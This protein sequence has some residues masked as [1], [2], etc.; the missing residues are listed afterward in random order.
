MSLKPRTLRWIIAGG[1]AGLVSIGTLALV[2]AQQS[3]A[4]KEAPD[5][6]GYDLKHPWFTGKHWDW[7][8]DMVNQ[9]SIKPQE[10]GTFQ[11]F[12]KDSVPR[13]GV[14]PFI[15]MDA[16]LGGKPARDVMPKNPVQATAASLANGKFIFNT[17]CAVCHGENGMAGT[18]VDAKG[19]PAPPI[20]PMFPVL[21]EAHLYNKALYGGPLMPS[22]GFQTSAKDRWD[23]VN[24]VKSAQF[25]K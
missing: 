1:V 23:L 8:L 12:P 2:S 18:K 21:S 19:M 9:P 16:M 7:F 3:E 13:T 17:Y 25:G 6:Q 15:P 4:R 11:D 10:E 20:A 22:Y 24:Y 5:Y 14:E